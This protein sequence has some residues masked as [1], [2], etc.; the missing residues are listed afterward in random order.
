MFELEFQFVKN[1]I[2]NG[3]ISGLHGVCMFMSLL[4]FHFH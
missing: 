4:N 3:G 1:G 2:K